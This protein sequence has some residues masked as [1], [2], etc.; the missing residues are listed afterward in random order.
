MAVCGHSHCRESKVCRYNAKERAKDAERHRDR[1]ARD[2]LRMRLR[3][4][5]RTNES[6][7]RRDRRSLD[8]ST[9]T[10]S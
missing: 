5:I 4:E 8:A 9:E 6:R 7:N 1:Y 3:A 10:E 2:P